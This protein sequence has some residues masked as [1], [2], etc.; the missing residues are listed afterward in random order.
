MWTLLPLSRLPGIDARAL[1]QAMWR[2]LPCLAKLLLQ[3]RRQQS[4]RRLLRLPQ[5]LLAQRAAVFCW[6]KNW[7]RIT[8]E[9]IRLYASTHPTVLRRIS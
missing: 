7:R 8:T 9:L 4:L 2:L 1:S 6:V 5:A 3:R